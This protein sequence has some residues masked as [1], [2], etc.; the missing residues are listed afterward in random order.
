MLVRVGFDLPGSYCHTMPSTA[1]LRYTYERRVSLHRSY[2]VQYWLLSASICSDKRTY[3]VIEA[4]IACVSEGAT[5]EL[6]IIC[7]AGDG[8]LSAST[9]A[10]SLLPHRHTFRRPSEEVDRSCNVFG[11]S[12]FTAAVE[13]A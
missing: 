1:E 11:G 7:N 6:C 9:S 10:S 3:P 8:W 13:E 12:S 5:T 4:S 2:L